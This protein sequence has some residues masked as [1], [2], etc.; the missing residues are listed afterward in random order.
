[1]KSIFDYKF[2]FYTSKM[3][4]VCLHC[5]LLYFSSIIL[6]FGLDLFRTMCPVSLRA[7]FYFPKTPCLSCIKLK[8]GHLFQAMFLGCSGTHST[9]LRHCTDIKSCSLNTIPLLL[10]PCFYPICKLYQENPIQTARPP[11]K[12]PMHF[13]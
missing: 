13:C 7:S 11:P 4:E 1:M 10:T 6:S 9:P 3:N 12:F 8:Q 5:H 2:R